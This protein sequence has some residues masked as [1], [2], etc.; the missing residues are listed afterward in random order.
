MTV[1]V[2]GRQLPA[3][4]TYVAALSAALLLLVITVVAALWQTE[5]TTQLNADMRQSLA[6]RS[7]LRL[8]MRGVQ[9]AETGQRGYLL[10]GNENYL[11]PYFAGRS[12]IEREIANIETYAGQNPER[13]PK[14][15]ACVSW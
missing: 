9:D 15:G 7:S 5:Q 6:Q 14:R 1:N 3:A 12:D 10:T 8:L 2:L 11:D 13:S 4:A